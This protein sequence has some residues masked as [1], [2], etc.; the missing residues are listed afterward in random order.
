MQAL[1]VHRIP[2]LYPEPIWDMP[3]QR[4]TLAPIGKY[5][6]PCH[7]RSNT[8]HFLGKITSALTISV[9]RSAL[10]SHQRRQRISPGLRPV[11]RS[12]RTRRDAYRVLG[13]AQ[14]QDRALL[15]QIVRAEQPPARRS[16][17]TDGF[18]ARI[19]GSF[20]RI[21]PR[22]ST[23]EHV[24]QYDCRSRRAVSADRIRERSG[25]CRHGGS[26]RRADGRDREGWRY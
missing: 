2:R 10:T 1:P 17:V 5:S 20:G 12:R 9:I 8:P 26:T 3:I 22:G 4:F 16:P 21:A 24:A 13:F 15:R 19:T 18:L 11:R 6:L 7:C 25:Q 14:A 23:V